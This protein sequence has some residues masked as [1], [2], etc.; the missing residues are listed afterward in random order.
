MKKILIG[1]LVVL[2]AIFT[3]SCSKKSDSGHAV[4]YTVGG[5]SKL[6]ITYTDADM[7]AKTV[8]GVTS[9]WTHTFST[10]STGQLVHLSVTSVDGTGVNGAIYIDGQQS[11][12]NDSGSGTV[13][14]SA[15]IP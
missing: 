11:T 13:N 3:V 10:S 15:Q 5:S 7:T 14:I 6:N 2:L 12:Q 9:T 8:S 4:K 1:S